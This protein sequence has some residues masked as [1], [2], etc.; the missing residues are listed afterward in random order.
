MSDGGIN[1]FWL[2]ECPPVWPP[3]VDRNRGLTGGVVYRIDGM[4]VG[5]VTHPC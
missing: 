5:V 3:G 1:I 2:Y 4:N